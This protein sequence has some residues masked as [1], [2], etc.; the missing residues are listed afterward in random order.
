MRSTALHSSHATAKGN[1]PSVRLDAATEPD[2]VGTPALSPQPGR[3]LLAELG[4]VT[5]ITTIVTAVVFRHQLRTP[6]RP[7]DYDGDG[8]IHGAWIDNMIRTGWINENP[9]LGA[10]FGQLY[11]DYPLGGDNLHFL[12]LRIGSLVTNDWSLLM[13]GFFLV[14]IPVTA[15][16]AHLSLRWMGAPRWIAGAASVLYAFA[17]VRFFRGTDHLFIASY[18]IVPIAVLLTFRAASGTLPWVPTRAAA[19]RARGVAASWPWLVAL[20]AIGACGADYFIFFCLVVMTAGALTALARRSVRPLVAALTSMA[21]SGF[22]FAIGL[23]PSMWHWRSNG[24]VEIARRSV[25]QQDLYGLRP[26]SLFSPVKHHALEVLHLVAGRLVNG[27]SSMETRQYMGVVIATVLAVMFVQLLRSV[28]AGEARPD[29]RRSLCVALVIVCIAVSTIGGL[30]WLGGLVG[31]TSI[32]AWARISPFIGFLALAWM[33]IGLVPFE[34]RVVTGTRTRRSIGIGV[35]A[36]ITVVGVIDQT[37][38]I[39]FPSAKSDSTANWTSDR[40]YFPMIEQA[41]G[42]GTSVFQLPIRRFPE[43]RATVD[44]TDYDLLRPSL[45]TSTLCFSYGG[46]KYRESEWQQQLVDRPAEEFL[47]DIVA[48]GFRALII[49][50][51]GYEDRAAGLEQQITALTSTPPLIDSTGRWATYDLEPF[52]IERAATLGAAALDDRARTLLGDDH[53]TMIDCATGRLVTASAP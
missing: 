2:G 23:A 1:L 28:V 15:I 6:R 37:P 45:N 39:R 17:P 53:E 36:A 9:R 38:R 22:S 29:P 32:R 44:S 4:V 49:D 51:Y 50:R 7:F 30:S 14:G 42:D 47:D 13:N 12:V 40:Q 21:I 24:R 20:L 31:F 52:A 5:L 33:S 34:Q 10:P 8:L 26:V 11:Y 48:T 3:R 43:E 18:A 19:T 41:L 16:T 27:E 46:M 35:L 25:F